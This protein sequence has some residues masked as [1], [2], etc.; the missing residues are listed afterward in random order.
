MKNVVDPTKKVDLQKFVVFGVAVLLFGFFAILRPA[1]ASY[2]NIMTI[3][4]STCVNGLLAIGVTFVIITGGI[5]LSVGPLMT[6][7][8][9][10]SGTALTVWGLPIWLCILIGIL[11]GIFIGMCSGLLVTKLKLPPFIATMAMMMVLKGLNLV[12]SGV[13]PIYFTSVKGYQKIALGSAFG[14]PGFYNAI[15]IFVAFAIV[16]HIIL[17]K[18]LLG[19]YA[20]AIGSNTQAARL[21]GIRVDTWII[22]VYAT[23]GFF[24]SI[25]GLIMSSRLNSAQPQLG[26]GYE[27]EAIAAAVIGGTSLA[28]GVGTIVGTLIGAFI[29]SELQNGLRTLAVS[30]EWQ[31][32]VIGM[33]LIL[34]VAVDQLRRKNV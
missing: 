16:G 32:V 10:M 23:S 30:P 14:I 2:S 20:Y 25:A 9:I 1:Y 7:T 5:D 6:F 19:R 18:T 27:L 4:L 29:M 15:L 31:F 17:S 3:V 13:K 33:V 11:S 26:P 28:G 8:G 24:C 12:I 34:S 22:V 21:S